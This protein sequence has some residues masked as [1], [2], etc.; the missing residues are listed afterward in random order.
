[1][2]VVSYPD[3]GQAVQQKIAELAPKTPMMSAILKFIFPLG[4]E[5]KRESKRQAGSQR[6]SQQGSDLSRS[7]ARLISSSENGLLLT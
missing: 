7:S 4:D 6:V 1:M 2:E 5:K 3:L